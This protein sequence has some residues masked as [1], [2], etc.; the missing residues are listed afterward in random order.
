[1][2]EACGEGVHMKTIL[3]TGELGTLTNVYKASLVS[4][5]AGKIHEFCVS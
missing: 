2:K 3:G 5:M 4:M 1:M